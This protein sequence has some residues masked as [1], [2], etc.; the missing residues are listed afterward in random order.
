MSSKGQKHVWQQWDKSIHRAENK[1]VRPGDAL[2]II[3]I[4]RHFKNI[5]KSW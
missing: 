1:F 3:Y 5:W 2:S 4:D